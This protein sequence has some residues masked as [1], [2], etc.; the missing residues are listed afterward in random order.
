MLAFTILSICLVFAIAG[1]S[2]RR[3]VMLEEFK[4]YS[5]NLVALESEK[6][7]KDL[8]EYLKGRYYYLANRLSMD[9][10]KGARDYGPVDTNVFKTLAVGK[11]PTSVTEEYRMFIERIKER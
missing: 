8:E 5:G 11:G 3:S 1:R 6:K 2:A 4:V 10:V 9:F 7:S